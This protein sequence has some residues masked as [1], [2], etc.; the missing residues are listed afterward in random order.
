MSEGRADYGDV[1]GE[2]L[3]ARSGHGIVSGFSELVWASGVD[4]VSFLDGQVSQDVVAMGEGTVARSLLLEPRGKL[5]ALLWLLRGSD[6]VGLLVGGGGSKGLIEELERFRFRVDVEFEVDDRPVI[7]VWGRDAESTVL[8]AGFT[9]G[10]GWLETGETVTASLPGT[11]RRVVLLGADETAL[12]A[13]GALRVGGV[14]ADTVRIE[15]GEPVMGRDVDEGTIPQESG[16]VSEAVSFTKGCFVGQ[17]LVARIDSRGR[18]NRRLAGVVIGTNV[19]PPVGAEVVVAD[20][21]VGTLSTV[22]ESLALRAPVALAM[23]HRSVVAGTEVQ[24]RWPE[25]STAAT[26]RQLPLDDFS[27]ISHSPN[28]MTRS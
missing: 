14:A 17:E 28:T 24:I 2:Y 23:V 26:V 1:T 19:V 9:I 7:E 13:A 6:R 16:L 18:V 27:G 20:D 15:A 8:R 4:T 12:Q 21:V 22:G 5:L 25:G 11:L 3:A 10:N